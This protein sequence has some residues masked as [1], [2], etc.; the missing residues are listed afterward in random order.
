MK[1]NIKDTYSINWALKP[2][3][4]HTNRDNPSIKLQF[5]W[6]LEMIHIIEYDLDI[7]SLC[8]AIDMT[9]NTY[10]W[11]LLLQQS[12]LVFFATASNTGG[13]WILKDQAAYE[14]W[15]CQKSVNESLKEDKRYTPSIIHKHLNIKFCSERTVQSL[16]PTWAKRIESKEANGISQSDMEV[17]TDVWSL[18]GSSTYARDHHAIADT[19]YRPLSSKN[20]WRLANSTFWSKQHWWDS[21]YRDI[22]QRM[23]KTTLKCIL[24]KSNPSTF[25]TNTL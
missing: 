18:T 13:N 17:V 8:T 23:N 10:V 24:R 16:C 21:H 15:P 14:Y 12:S 7:P 9:S 2:A 5:T 11:S 19:V 1:R 3:N 25:T 4:E 20:L 6:F 22:Y